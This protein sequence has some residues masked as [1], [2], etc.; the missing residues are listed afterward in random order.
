M[1]N[2]AA[3]HDGEQEE[4]EVVIVLSVGDAGLV[5]VLITRDDNVAVGGV[6]RVIVV[7][8]ALGALRVTAEGAILLRVDG[9]RAV[10]GVIKASEHGEE[11][12]GGEVGRHLGETQVGVMVFTSLSVHGA[13][14]QPGEPGGAG[15]RHKQLGG[16]GPTGNL[17][18]LQSPS[19]I[20]LGDDGVLIKTVK[21]LGVGVD[22][23]GVL[24]VEEGTEGEHV[25]TGASL[26]NLGGVER[27]T[28]NFWHLN[29]ADIYGSSS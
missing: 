1:G 21:K 13:V 17:L 5:V 27:K 22:H 19:L 15:S 20:E 7:V 29:I 6:V 4:R 2:T 23:V 10:V 3:K 8:T 28:L 24:V 12:R 26:E 16:E 18:R 25:R 14:Q 9:D 11:Q